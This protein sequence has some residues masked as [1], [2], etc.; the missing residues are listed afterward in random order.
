M[1]L[2]AIGQLSILLTT[3]QGF[4]ELLLQRIPRAF[5]QSQFVHEVILTPTLP[6]RIPG[7]GMPP[8]RRRHNV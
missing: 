8:V 7:R 3:K 2:E 6:G 1:G 4:Q 5:D